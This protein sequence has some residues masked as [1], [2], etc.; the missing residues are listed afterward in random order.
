M[1][2]RCVS[3]PGSE[4]GPVATVYVR[5]GETPDMSFAPLMRSIAERFNAR[6]PFISKKIPDDVEHEILALPLEDDIQL[7]VMDDNQKNSYASLTA[8]GMRKVHSDK[9]FRAELSRWVVQNYSLRK[10]GIPGYTMLVPGPFSLIL[11]W[12]LRTFNLGSIL[13]LLNT[14]SILSSSRASLL[15]SKEDSPTAWLA[16]GR[17]FERISLLL[18]THGI[19]TSIY[20]ASVEVPELRE[21]LGALEGIRNGFPQ[22]AFTFGYP[23]VELRQSPRFSPEERLIN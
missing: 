22:F 11:P 13:A 4:H 2:D 10:D 5:V 3:T 20:V 15:I 12:M 6:G 8:E 7:F 1:F 17:S 9:E 16:T 21:K 14:K 19:R 23:K 18:A